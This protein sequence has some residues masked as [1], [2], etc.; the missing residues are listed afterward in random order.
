MFLTK[1]FQGESLSGRVVVYK[2]SQVFGY[3]VLTME[4]DVNPRKIKTY[5]VF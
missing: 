2:L 1:F 4:H 5:V 3:A